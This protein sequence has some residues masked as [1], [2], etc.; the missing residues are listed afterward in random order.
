[1]KINELIESLEEIRDN[2]G[3]FEVRVALQP[4]YPLAASIANIAVQDDEPVVWL[5]TTEATEYASA[6]AWEAGY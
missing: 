4:T 3:E 5:A 1:V 6:A 2:Y